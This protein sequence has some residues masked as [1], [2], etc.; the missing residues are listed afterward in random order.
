[1][2]S[3]PLDEGDVGPEIEPGNHNLSLVTGVPS[4]KKM[5]GVVQSV[6]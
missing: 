1:V 4:W 2:S 6:P 3:R 5:C